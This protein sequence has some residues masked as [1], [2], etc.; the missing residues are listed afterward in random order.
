MAK[1]TSNVH[2]VDKW[3]GVIVARGLQC[4]QYCRM[5]RDAWNMK[6]TVQTEAQISNEHVKGAERSTMAAT[7]SRTEQATQT[8]G[9]RDEVPF[10]NPN[11][12]NH[13]PVR[14]LHRYTIEGEHGRGGLGRVFKAYDTELERTVAIKEMLR[15][16]RAE[17]RFVREAK[18]TA[19]LEHPGIV[20]LYDAGRWPDGDPFY[21]MKLVSGR[22]LKERIAA[23]SSREERFALITHVLAVADAIAYAHSKG[24]I[25]RDLKP[26]N[27][28]IGDYGETIVI[29]W[30][31]AKDL[32]RKHDVIGEQASSCYTPARYALTSAGDILGTPSYMSPEQGRGDSVDERT[33]VYALGAILYHVLVGQP[34]RSTSRAESWQ[35]D[36]V[37]IAHSQTKSLHPMMPPDLVAIIDKAMSFDLAGRYPTARSFAEDLRRFQ[38]GKLVQAHQYSLRSL[39]RRWV[40]RYRTLVITALVAAVV[41]ATMAVLGVNQIVKERDVARE[42][43][44]TARKE[45]TVARGAESRAIKERNRLVLAN[46]TS[47]LATNPSAAL[48]HLGNYNGDEWDRVRDITADAF[49]RGVPQ[50]LRSFGSMVTSVALLSERYLLAQVRANVTGIYDIESAT[51]SD[52]EHKIGWKDVALSPRGDA[53][54]SRHTSGGTSVVRTEDGRVTPLKV[55]GHVADAG[56]IGPDEIVTTH[57]DGGLAIWRAS[58]GELRK[59][60]YEDQQVIRI[61]IAKAHDFIAICDAEGIL[62]IRHLNAWNSIRRTTCAPS[63]AIGNI[64]GFSRNGRFYLSNSAG[65]QM[66]L[67]DLRSSAEH[68]LDILPRYVKEAAFSP[69]S[70]LLAIGS[71]E[72]DVHIFELV[73]Q[74]RIP[75]GDEFRQT[76]ALNSSLELVATVRHSSPVTRLRWA[77]KGTVLASADI[78]GGLRLWE[79]NGHSRSFKGHSRAIRALAFSP[80]GRRLVTGDRV[81]H[82]KLWELPRP[83]TRKLIELTPPAMAVSAS[84]SGR[85]VA[86]LDT[87]YRILVADESGE[88]LET[89][90]TEGVQVAPLVF[91]EDD[92]L[93]YI[94]AHH[95]I[96]ASRQATKFED[97]VD[98]GHEHDDIVAIEQIG[99]DAIALAT[100]SGNLYSWRLGERSP[101]QLARFSTRILGLTGGAYMPHVGVLLANGQ[102][103]VYTPTS[104][105]TTYVG[106]VEGA[107]KL[108][109][110]SP[111]EAIFAD[112]A[113]VHRME[114]AV[115][116]TLYASEAEVRLA[117]K[118]KEAPIVAFA[119]DDSAYAL[120][121]ESGELYRINGLGSVVVSVALSVGGTYLAAG[122]ED[123]SV[124]VLELV[125]R[126]VR[127]HREHSSP[128]YYIHF[129]GAGQTLVTAGYDAALRAWDFMHSR[130]QGLSK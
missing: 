7:P 16:S 97:I 127:V 13:L 89:L 24:I 27:I 112:H 122:R 95:K 90:V 50:H 88:Q 106:V 80:D 52:V 8:G 48:E 30:G 38:D 62:T 129:L 35:S 94:E 65:D 9:Q 41:L 21:T 17:E 107:T 93:V 66:I 29:D 117:E 100:S 47:A 25:H 125:D 74:Q 39:V 98:F 15:P 75:S 56:F 55:P 57:G 40:L 77:P 54:V 130:A 32:N 121:Y 82:V 60:M 119:E 6:Q 20:P 73:P 63:T 72:G 118:A 92:T 26:S 11:A 108:L 103:H 45:R 87:E 101:T 76:A 86:A 4:E 46:A 18:I 69:D 120:N 51:W 114:N 2:K 70:T 3:L 58:N 53:F 68:R 28:I 109:F 33:D 110:A 105:T 64:S 124:I 36:P 83:Q 113:G 128:V 19:R 67:V 12:H 71:I 84:P 1:V 102:V 22:S 85:L 126:S 81:G 78:S 91:L 23:T 5:S 116:E 115:S 104:A 37:P 96:R 10:E 59:R 42:E 79:P 61:D 14:D 99:I 31:I 43:R 34:P 44:A 123:G 111:T 49:T